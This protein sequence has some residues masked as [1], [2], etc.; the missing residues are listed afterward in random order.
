M[1]MLV[2]S[3]IAN[4]PKLCPAVK[5]KVKDPAMIVVCP[6]KA[7]QYDMEPK[8]SSNG[9]T[10]VVINPDVTE[11]SQRTDRDGKK[12]LWQKAVTVNIII[13]AAEQ[14]KT[15][16]YEMVL[17][18]PSFTSRVIAFGV[19]EVHLLNSW[20]AEFR[21]ALRQIGTMRVRMPGSPILMGLTATLRC[22]SPSSAVCS[23]LHLREGAFHLIRLSNARHD[24]CIIVRQMQSGV[25]SLRFPE[26]DWV[27]QA[28]R[29]I[30]I[31]CTT[32]SFGFRIVSY[33]WH[34]ASDFPDRLDRIRMYNSLYPASYNAQTLEFMHDDPRPRVTIATD[35]LAVGIDAPNTDDVILIGDV[36][37]T[38]DDILQKAGRIRDGRGRDSRLI[39]ID[40]VRILSI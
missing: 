9:L 30:I 38:T 21:P 15:K 12:K 35:T 24:I 2:Y 10:T 14:L 13:L 8:F 33:L 31:F 26:L 17:E 32:I 19:D 4:N 28:N 7:L 23:L 25:R 36:P 40:L 5:F 34:R 6:T 11:L 22:G 20:G 1:Y 37:V 16:E 3:A 18:D 39:F 27:L 29:K